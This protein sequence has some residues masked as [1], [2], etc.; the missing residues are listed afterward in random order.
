[1][2]SLPWPGRAGVASPRIGLVCL[3]SVPPTS[4]PCSDGGTRFSQSVAPW[5]QGPHADPVS[6]RPRSQRLSVPA[7]S[8]T[9]ET[10]YCRC[11]ICAYERT[12]NRSTY[13]G[14]KMMIQNVTVFRGIDRSFLDSAVCLPAS[15]CWCGK[16]K[17][18]SGPCP[19]RFA[20]ASFSPFSCSTA[21]MPGKTSACAAAWRAA[22]S[23]PA[24]PAAWPAS[25]WRR[26]P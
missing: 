9:T 5:P 11:A 24:P 25:P 4:Q 16:R 26:R 14:A 20:I 1:M 10:S 22:S 6:V 3:A 8:A 18:T 7:R 15:R 17:H 13:N 19:C 12:T 21:T 23:F 2:S